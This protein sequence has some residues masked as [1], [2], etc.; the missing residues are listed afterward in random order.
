MARDR[1]RRKL[2]QRCRRLVA[3]LSLPDPFDIADFVDSLAACRGRPIELV[4]VTGRPNL[5]CGL[6]LTTADA[7]YILYAAD[8]SPL[9]Q[10]HILLHEA[11][12]L[13][14]GHQDD[15]AGA[16]LDA[17]ARTLMPGLSPALVERVLGRTIYTEPQE[18]EAEIVASL[19]LSR[20][21]HWSP[22]PFAARA[23]SLEALFDRRER[24]SPPGGPSSS[25]GPDG[26]PGAGPDPASGGG[27]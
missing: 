6:L 20:V 11:A 5:P 14:C 13:L 23:R 8:T 24:P 2:W 1:S 3:A 25:G 27:R 10:Q 12:H 15:S 21:S 17:A 7:D 19:I 16:T 9:H 22:P 26:R 4:P 18:R